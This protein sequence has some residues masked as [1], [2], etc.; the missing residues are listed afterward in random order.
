MQII[1][2]LTIAFVINMLLVL[3]ISRAH[4]SYLN[5]K[6]TNDISKA[7]F[8]AQRLTR[9]A[10]AP[11]TLSSKEISKW[12]QWHWGFIGIQ[13]M[14]CTRLI[15]EIQST[16]LNYTLPISMLSFIAIA[17]FQSTFITIKRMANRTLANQNATTLTEITA[18]A[19]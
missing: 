19:G 16:S 8:L 2:S 13:L 15:N 3:F 10:I 6:Y 9:T 12:S 4:E 17:F 5:R 18:H 7:E 14:T 11:K 1:T